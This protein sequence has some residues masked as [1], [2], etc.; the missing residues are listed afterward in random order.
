MADD[1]PDHRVIFARITQEASRKL[2]EDL[3]V[4]LRERSSVQ[5]T[6]AM[7]MVYGGV[8]ELA[9]KGIRGRM[10]LASSHEPLA[11]TKPIANAGEREWLAELTNQ[12]MGRIKN[13]LLLY[14]VEVTFGSPVTLRAE[15]L[16][17]QGRSKEAPLLFEGGGGIVQVSLDVHLDRTFQMR[18]RPD[19][20][21]AGPE[22]GRIILF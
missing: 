22:Q 2:F 17:A 18:D 19:P 11:A 6:G 8:I 10:T 5:G 9:G 15:H 3:G 4:T 20:K 7:P 13:Q 21:L 12:L 16:I 1:A 14:A